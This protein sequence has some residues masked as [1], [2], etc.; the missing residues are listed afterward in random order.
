LNFV[1]FGLG[2]LVLLYLLAFAEWKAKPA[3]IG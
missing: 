1:P 3:Q 2:T